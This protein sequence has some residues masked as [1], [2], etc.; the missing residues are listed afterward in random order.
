MAR[1]GINKAL[2]AKAREI[3]LARGENP[4]TD[5]VHIELGNI[6]SK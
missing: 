1:G 3:V 6:G 2:V 4:S 5:A